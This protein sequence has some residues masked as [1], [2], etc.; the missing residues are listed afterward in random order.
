MAAFK[1]YRITQKRIEERLAES[2][3]P[4]AEGGPEYKL[5]CAYKGYQV[6]EVV[7]GSNGSNKIV[8]ALTPGYQSASYVWSFVAG[9]PVISREESA[10]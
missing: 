6:Q 3:R 9:L 2:S 8:R 10:S 7:Y 4:L 5:S 1:R